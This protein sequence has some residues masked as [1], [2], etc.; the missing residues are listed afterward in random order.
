MAYRNIFV[1]SSSKVTLRNQQ[2]I[3]KTEEEYS[4]PLEDISTIMLENNQSSIS[5]AVLSECAKNGVLVY[6]CDEKHIPCGVLTGFHTHSRQYKMLQSQIQTK[7]TL[8]KHLWSKIVIQKIRN[9]AKV[10]EILGLQGKDQIESLSKRV[11]L[12]DKE[13]MEAVAAAQYFKLLFGNRFSRGQSNIIN[14]R[15]NYGYAIIRGLLCRSITVYGLEPSLGI[16]HYS[17]LNA[18]N[19]ADDIIEVF[20]PMVD[21]CV[22]QMDEGE[23][24]Y[25]TTRDK[26]ILYNIVNCDVSFESQKHPLFYGIEKTVQTFQSSIVMGE[27]Q[28]KLCELLPLRQHIY[29]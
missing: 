15:L 2:L 27:D 6:F 13:N 3:I 25:L 21:L 5:S 18:F 7:E 23:R 17:Q 24:E 9:Q 8:K 11:K 28:L 12:N 4:F 16:H 10:L 20:R 26:Q 29:E 22:Y 14:A 1:S 19:L